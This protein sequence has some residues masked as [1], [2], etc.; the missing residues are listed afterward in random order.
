MKITSFIAALLLCFTT[1]VAQKTTINPNDA[2]IIDENVKIL[3]NGTRLDFIYYDFIIE[4]KIVIKSEK[5]IKYFSSVKIPEN[6]DPTLI[7]HFPKDRNYQNAFSNIAVKKFEAIISN[8]DGLRAVNTKAQKKDVQIVREN[9][10]YGTYNYFTCD[11][12][13]LEIGDTLIL[14]YNYEIKFFENMTKLLSSRY[15]FHSN[16]K[17]QHS[18]LSVVRNKKL[19]IV[20]TTYNNAEADTIIESDNNIEHI[21][22][23]SNLEGCIFEPGSRPFIELANITFSIE[24]ADLLYRHEQSL[25]AERMPAWAV[26]VGYRESNHGGIYAA[27]DQG[28]KTK[29]YRLIN[30]FVNAKISGISN[31]STGIEKLR[32]IHHS[33]VEDFEFANDLEYFKNIDT[34]DQRIGEYLASGRLRDVSRYDTYIALIRSL[35]L[36]YFTS[37]LIDNRSGIIDYNFFS[38]L[39]ESDYLIAAV[40]N[41]NKL[42]YIYPKKH[43]YAYYLNELPFYYENTFCYLVNM[44]NYLSP[45]RPISDRLTSTYTPKS[46]LKSNQRMNNIMVDVDLDGNVLKFKSQTKLKGQFSTLCRGSYLCD[47]VDETINKTYAIKVWDINDNVKLHKKNAIVTSKEFPFNTKV[48][49][50]FDLPNAVKKEGDIYQIDLTNWFNHIIVNG[51]ESKN[52][53]LNFYADFIGQDSYVYFFKFSENIELINDSI[54]CIISNDFAKYEL[55]VEQIQPKSIKISSSFITHNNIVEPEKIQAVI[56][57]YSKIEDLNKYILKIK[58]E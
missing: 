2:E 24:P 36:N 9:N 40:T 41:D 42:Q 12:N 32:T 47:Y 6:F 48:T 57:V 4:K 27:I 51:V 19:N 22:K 56:D 20:Y 29:Q 44:Y 7:K 8:K 43:K 17:K 49:A 55:I 34:R 10:R 52:R 18:T 53:N 3:I 45:E 15:F 14:N 30:S 13:N 23:Y 54:S 46:S 21:W 50:E 58:K 35:E 33:I 31:D 26:Y 38:P 28:V 1:L 16:I 5:G 37:Y 25:V 11:I 39:S